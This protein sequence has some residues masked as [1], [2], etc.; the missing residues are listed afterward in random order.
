MASGGTTV[1]ATSSILVSGFA[2]LHRWDILRNAEVNDVSG[3]VLVFAR[4]G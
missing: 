4:R 2:I 3:K 1:E